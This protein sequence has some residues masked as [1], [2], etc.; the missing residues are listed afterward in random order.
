MPVNVTAML[1]TLVH[2]AGLD[3]RS[4]C[5]YAGKC[6]LYAEHFSLLPGVTRLSLVS[7]LTSLT[8]TS[9]ADLLT[10]TVGKYGS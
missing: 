10:S 8:S 5:W 6:D 1:S 9:T 7:R 4:F 2:L 3:V